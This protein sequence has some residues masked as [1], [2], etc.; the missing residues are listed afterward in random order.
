MYFGYKSYSIVF[1]QIFSTSIFLRAEVLNFNSL[2]PF[3]LSWVTL[4][5]FFFLKPHCQTQ[6]QWTN[7]VPHTLPW[8]TSCTSTVWWEDGPFSIDLHFFLCHRSD[9]YH[10]SDTWYLCGLF[11]GCH[12]FHWCMCVFSY[13]CANLVCILLTG[14]VFCLSMQTLGSSVHI[15]RAL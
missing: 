5:V 14:K 11:L 12:L 9:K 2:L 13:Q 8:M 6:G 15:E 10:W 3:P 1:P 4:F 7:L